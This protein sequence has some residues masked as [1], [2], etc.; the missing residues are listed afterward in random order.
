MH[1]AYEVPTISVAASTPATTDVDVLLVPVAQDHTAEAVA[2]FDGAV[3]GDLKSALDR[4]EF[5]AKDVPSIA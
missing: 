3:G 2:A 5:R 1:V 4:G